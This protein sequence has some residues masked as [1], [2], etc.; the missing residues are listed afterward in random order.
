MPSAVRS[1]R[2]RIR[3]ALGMALA[4]AGCDDKP[5]PWSRGDGP[6]VVLAPRGS[7]GGA[8]GPGGGQL[9]NAAEGAGGGPAQDAAGGGGSAPPPSASGPATEAPAVADTGPGAAEPPG[10]RPQPGGPWVKCHEGFTLSGEPV[11][12]VTRLGLLCGPSNGMRRK[13]RQAIVGLGGQHEPPVSAQIQGW[14]G[15]CYRI[16]AAADAQ[17]SELDVTVRSSR[18]VGV[19]ADHTPGRLAIVQP[20]R[21]FCMLADEPF[22]VEISVKRGSGR[23][24]AEVWALGE[25][26][27]RRDPM[28]SPLDEPPLDKP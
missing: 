28:D 4:L 21:P 27:K 15:A 11:R 1:H 17:V 10:P 20:D 26:R 8:Q 18:E 14:R 3:L 24:A 2:S 5:R 6:P 22:T 9:A 23:F 25:P 16:F 13:T 7:V 12:D 19:A